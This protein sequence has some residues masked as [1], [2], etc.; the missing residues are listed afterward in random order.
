MQ[1]AVG[2]R[3][4]V[5]LAVVPARE[6][7]HA[8]VG[9]DAAHVGRSTGD[10]PRGDDRA[11]REVDDADGSRVAVRDVQV[12]RVAARVQ[13]RA[14]RR[15][16]GRN[17]TT[18]EASARRPPTRRRSS[19]RRR[20]RCVPSGESFTSCGTRERPRAAR[21]CCTTDWSCDVDHDEVARELAAR[22]RE[23]PVGREV[24]VVDAACTAPVPTSTSVIEL[25]SRK[26]SRLL[27]LGDDDRVPAVGREVQVVRIGHGDRRP[28]RQAGVRVDRREAVAVVVVDVER[29]QVPRRRDVLGQRADREVL[30]DLHGRRIDHVDRVRLAVRHVHQRPRLPGDRAQRRWRRRGRTRRASRCRPSDRVD[31]L[32]HAASSVA[33]SSCDRR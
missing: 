3:D 23:R 30:D 20:R 27:R 7:E 25:G 17:P 16:V 18:V 4:R 24:H 5:H 9:R 14:R 2:G 29:L 32:A 10:R 13:A 21:P 12:L 28:A 1:V 15:P 19:C 26:S 11:G 8:T 31:D 6:P 22:E 33:R